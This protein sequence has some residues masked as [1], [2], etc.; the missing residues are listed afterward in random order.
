MNDNTTPTD[1]PPGPISA[2]AF[3]IQPKKGAVKA[4]KVVKNDLKAAGCHWQ[5][6]AWSCPLSAKEAIE[7]LLKRNNIG[8]TLRSFQDDYFCKEKRGQEADK[9]WVQID[10]LE[11]RHYAEFTALLV[12][13]ET[14]EQEVRTRGLALEDSHVQMR[15]EQLD[16]RE[17]AQNILMEEIVQLRNSCLLYTSPSPRDRG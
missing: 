1:T 7:T 9:V 17:K 8:V 10:I 2:N 11:K 12:D 15:L 16:D 13:R 14:L 3:L 5:I 6:G 4:L